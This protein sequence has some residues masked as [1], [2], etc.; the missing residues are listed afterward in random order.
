MR[1][2]AD[3]L[4]SDRQKREIRR[5]IEKLSSLE[6]QWELRGR[7]EMGDFDDVSNAWTELAS[8]EMITETELSG[9][10]IPSAK[11]EA[12]KKKMRGIALE[13]D[14]ILSRQE[15]MCIKL[16]IYESWTL[17]ETAA[18]LR[19]SRSATKTYLTRAISKLKAHFTDPL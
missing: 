11:V 19:I 15:R 18:K 12:L 6:S 14:G 1:K 16:H 2:D 5:E 13:V 17:A 10:Y 3:N 9:P 8:L 4:L 7:L